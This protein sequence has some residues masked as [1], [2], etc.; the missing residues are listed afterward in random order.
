[1]EQKLVDFVGEVSSFVWGAPRN[2][3]L[4]AVG[5]KADLKIKA[6]VSGIKVKLITTTAKPPRT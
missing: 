1:M 3:P 2:P 6:K 4:A 5:V